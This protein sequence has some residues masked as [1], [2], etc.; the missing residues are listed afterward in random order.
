MKM[1]TTDYTEWLCDYED[2]KE[3]GTTIGVLRDLP[4][5][6][7]ILVSSTY[8]FK[9]DPVVKKLVFCGECSTKIQSHLFSMGFD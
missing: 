5:T 6:P 8:R 2:C 1:G 4:P 9:G 7:W 3:K